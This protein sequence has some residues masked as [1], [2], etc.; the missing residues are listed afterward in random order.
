MSM[1]FSFIFKVLA[2]SVAASG[3]AWVIVVYISRTLL[4]QRL[5]VELER[6]KIEFGQELEAFKL[7]LGKDLHKFSVELSRLDQQRT[8]GIWR[9]MGLYATLSS[10]SFGTLVQQQLLL[11]L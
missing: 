2:T 8:T 11:Y 3:A 4:T 5:A 10:L 7:G 1:P 6:Q 9:S